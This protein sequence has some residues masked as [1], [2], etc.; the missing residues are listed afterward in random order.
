MPNAA[1]HIIIPLLIAAVIRDFVV[2]RRFSTFYV[3]TAGIAG[4]LPDLDIIFY[5]FLNL[6]RAVPLA[7]VHRW[8]FHSL[9]IPLIFLIPALIFY[10][11]KKVSLFFLMVT[12]GTF[13][14]IVL[15][16]VLSGYLR[17]F[18]P[19]SSL[20]LGL[21]LIPGSELGGTIILGLDAV[22]LVLWLIWEYRQHNI[23]D[24]I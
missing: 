21:N 15:D 5:W 16:L 22:L 8:F 13:I 9:A 7:E 11:K 19:L 4:L 20:Q 3:L 18:Y 6:F 2:K 23:K 10:K 17:P 24:Y 1:T 12:L 14:H